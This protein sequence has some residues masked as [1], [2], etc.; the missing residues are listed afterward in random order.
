VGGF[1]PVYT[2]AGDDVDL[3]W[4]TLD[5]SWSIGFHPAAVV[6]HHRRS[7]LRSYL[8]QQ[9]E[10]GRS[11]A[12]V[13]ARHPQRFTRAG[14]ARWRGR[15]YNSVPPSLGWQRSYRGPYGAA[16]YQSVYQAGGDVLDLVHQIGIPIAASLA[17][18]APLAIL[19]PWLGL[20]AL[21]AVLGLAGLA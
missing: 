3:C 21:I 14:T 5:R 1:D 12:L 15:I 19:S 16:A 11:E 20:P 6:W 9:A 2:Q 18:T 4:K 7:G 13:E 10:Y 8:R 17:L